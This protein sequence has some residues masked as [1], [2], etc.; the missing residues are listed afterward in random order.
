M[1]LMPK[2]LNVAA[3]GVGWASTN[4][5]LVSMADSPK[6][7][8]LG[9]IDCFPGRA[10]S[11]AKDHGYSHFWESDNLEDVPWLDKVNAVAVG[12]S[13]DAHYS[14]I[15]SA[16]KLGKH[17]ITEKPFAMTVK[18]GYELV[19]L[20]KQQSLT[21]G[22]VH[23]FQF[24]SSTQKLLKDLQSGCFGPIKCIVASQL[25]NPRRRLP[26]WYEEL[27]LGLFYDES[28]HF[29]YLISRL[30]PG[31][32]KFLR[33]DV[34]PSSLG[35]VTPA[36]IAMQYRCDSSEHGIIPVTVNMNFEAT[37][38]EWHLTVYGEKYMGDIDIFRDIYI[39]LPNDGLHTTKTV[40]RTSVLATSQHWAQ[41]F[42]SGIKHLTGKLRYGNDII[43]EKF[44]DAV[45]QDRPL[46]E[47][48]ATDALSVLE[49]QHEI[50]QNQNI[51][52]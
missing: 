12:A 10:A 37:V 30:S 18:E 34:H 1:N 6:F 24:A 15:K 22:I 42:T 50:I 29:F 40:L 51:L 36:A 13:P 46:Q 7:D 31:P 32:L 2:K 5:H 21:L 25:S 27:P 23:N 33:A 44:A 17:V 16:L 26:L 52:Y 39:R 4:R 35:M 49:M 48:G 38:S 41:H 47:V 11:V 14:L 8:V 43:F 20:A 3:V 28:P 19:E 9:A 45:L